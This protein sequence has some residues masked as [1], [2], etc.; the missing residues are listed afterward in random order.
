MVQT[1][2]TYLCSTAASSTLLYSN[3]LA[4]TN[5][6]SYQQPLTNKH[7][8]F[9][10]SKIKCKCTIYHFCINTNST[11]SLIEC[12]RNSKDSKYH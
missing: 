7:C 2:I 11:C 10:D 5:D 1:C 6:F 8:Y 12:S 3:T 4:H 9:A